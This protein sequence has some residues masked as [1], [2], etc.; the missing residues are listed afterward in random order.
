VEECSGGDL[1]GDEFGVIWDSILIFPSDLVF[2]PVDYALLASDAKSLAESN[3]VKRKKTCAE[4]VVS[5]MANSQ[6]GKIART[7]LAIS[8]HLDQRAA[9]PIARLLAREQSKAVDYPKTGADE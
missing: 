2:D 4:F 8:D 3:P 1:D 9:D 7:H 5:A 6:L